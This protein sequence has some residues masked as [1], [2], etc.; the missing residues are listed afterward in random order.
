MVEAFNRIQRAA[1]GSVRIKGRSQAIPNEVSTDTGAEFKG[2]FSQMLEN[3]GISQRFKEATNSLAVV[4]AA[5][6]TIKTTIAKTMVDTS[7]DSWAKAL[8]AA[9]KAHNSNSHPALLGSPPEDV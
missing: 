8:P 2:V 7:D 1:R 5:I 3:E 9:V 6:R 4:D